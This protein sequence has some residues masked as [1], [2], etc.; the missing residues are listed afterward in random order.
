VGGG[1]AGDQP[2][3]FGEAESENVALIEVDTL[4]R[5]E[6]V[7]IFADDHLGDAIARLY[8]RYAEL[9]PAGAQRERAATTARTIAAG[10]HWGTTE[11][12]LSPEI[13]FVD[14]RPLGL[15]SARGIDAF[16]RGNR[17]QLDIAG[18]VEIRADDVLALRPNAYLVAWMT[19]GT[20]RDGGGRF[21]RPY[22]MLRAFEPDG[23][24]RH[25]EWF[26]T[27][28]AEQALARFDELTAPLAP[29]RRVPANAATAHAARMDAAVAARDLDA[30]LDLLA[31]DAQAV[32]H[33]TGTLYAER[34]ARR[35][36]EIMLAN[37]SLVFS[38]EPLA[39]LG[40]TLALCRGNLSIGVSQA[41]DLPFGAS[42]MDSLVLMEVDASGRRRATEF[43]ALDKLAD[44]VC[45]LY[46]RH[47][48]LLPDGPERTRVAATARSL[49]ALLG[50][51]DLARF[52]TGIA[53]ALDVADYRRIGLE[54][55][56]G[57]E[58][59]LRGLDSLVE[60]ADDIANRIDDVLALRSSVLLLR[61]VNS[62]T[63]RVGGG[64]YERRFLYLG[65][66]GPDGL[67]ARLELFEPDREAEAL[68]RFD[69]L[70]AE[71]P[72]PRF[73]NA[74]SRFF[75][76]FARCWHARDWQGVVAVYAPTIRLIDRRSLMGMDLEGSEFI[77]NLQVMFEMGVNRWH[78]ELL[79]TRGERLALFRLRVQGEN[80]TTG[81]FE[82]E[83]LGL[84]E[85]DAG[86]RGILSVLF[87][88]DDRDA[89]YAELDARYHAGEA[90]AQ[91]S[92]A[93]GMREF[94]RA[95]AARD[96]DALTARCAP[97]IA[98]HD[99][100]RLGWETL[101]G[102]AA[103]VRALR[104]LVEL[105]PDTALRL[106]HVEMREQ[107]Y[108]VV[109]V[110]AGT[111]DG[112][113]FEE[114]SLM[115]AEL[116]SSGRIR[117][118]D[119]YEL[120][121]L[122]EARARYASIAPLASRDPLRIPPNAATR[123][124]DR[125]GE[126]AAARDWDATASLLA[127][128][129]RFDDRRRGILDRGD[130]AKMLASVRI[131]ADSGARAAGTTLATAGDRLA[132]QRILFSI[133]D[134]DAVMAEIE[135]LQV[136][137]IDAE[138][139]LV[140]TVTFDPDDRRAASAELVERYAAS[141]VDESLRASRL[142]M[143]RAI[144]DHDLDGVRAAMRP[145]FVYHDRRRVGAGRLEGEDYIAWLAA[146]FEQSP[147]ALIAPLYVVAGEPHGTLSVGHTFGTRVEGGAFESVFVQVAGPFGVELYDLEDLDAARAR[148][149]ALRG[150]PA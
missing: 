149:E 83:Y 17:S 25:V 89:A 135:T 1:L 29:V 110:W 145:G 142:A 48:E 115:V 129:F 52:A 93:A 30:F 19:S 72:E 91:P 94:S 137:E 127:P 102:A 49:A 111:R 41:E 4:G 144:R 27:D 141:H 132:L 103:Y 123:A 81:P 44:A 71:A 107:D 67:L 84:V 113:A 6:R 99:H 140:A 130:R 42:N 14:H 86:G 106:D 146:L 87:D 58:A 31:D 121:R 35:A 112:G 34:E 96:W 3:P 33:Q 148:F 70:T 22:L 66:F 80:G 133:S 138:G 61:F 125:F 116:D 37:E 8:E 50:P 126:A 122:A 45:R 12:I 62:G 124:M 69:E 20:L 128:G 147:D 5:R 46:E 136:V 56:H 120:E 65:V 2:I 114:P 75:D 109:T 7:E 26:A 134:G 18:E 119:Q 9:L 10:M 79:A 38:H 74:A 23:R 39:T 100:R 92:V 104:A 117:R 40:D 63:A 105:A 53:P 98:V 57:A 59:W 47:A 13:E 24:L 143:A 78:G 118:F 68:A 16:M 101:Y 55:T 36:Y 90:A 108:L 21:E 95:F 85:V 97:A 15:G 64:S 88:P 82:L 131:A 32:H 51:F 11:A 43:F 77:A 76:A 150:D 73:A 139:R 60:I 28:R 54:P